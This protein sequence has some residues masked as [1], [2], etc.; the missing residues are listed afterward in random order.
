MENVC[1]QALGSQ[2]YRWFVFFST[3][4]F[5]LVVPK[6]LKCLKIKFETDLKI[7][8]A[9]SVEQIEVKRECGQSNAFHY[10]KQF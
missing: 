1:F 9:Q 3:F 4:V 2:N 8:L 6:Y 10:G 5:S 7:K